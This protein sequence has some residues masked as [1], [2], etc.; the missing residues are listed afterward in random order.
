MNV[1]DFPVYSILTAKETQFKSIYHKKQ[2]TEFTEYDFVVEYRIQRGIAQKDAEKL[3][4][5][6]VTHRELGETLRRVIKK[7]NDIYYEMLTEVPNSVVSCGLKPISIEAEDR[8]H[9][10]KV[11]GFDH[12]TQHGNECTL[13]DHHLYGPAIYEIENMVIEGKIKIPDLTL[14]L[15]INHDY[16]GKSGDHRIDPERV[17]KVMQLGK[18][19]Y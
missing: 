13:C 18:Y 19:K 10:F 6:G 1:T 16:F 7:A 4:S 14:H 15:L 11:S 2:F 8:G 9:L 3:E 5:I 17:C 12:R